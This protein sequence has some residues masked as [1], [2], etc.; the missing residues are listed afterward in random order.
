MEGDAGFIEHSLLPPRQHFLPR[1]SAHL[2]E[3]SALVS[4]VTPTCLSL[5]P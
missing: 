5:S 3:E 1:L 2:S 4:E